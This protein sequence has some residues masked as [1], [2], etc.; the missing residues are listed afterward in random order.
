MAPGALR[1]GFS[2]IGSMT[3]GPDGNIYLVERS[4]PEIRVYS[5]EGDRLRTFGRSGQGPGEFQSPGSIGF[6]ADTLW[7]ADPAGQRVTMF[8]ETGDVLETFPIPGVVPLSSDVAG[9]LPMAMG[10]R[11]RSDGFVYFEE[12]SAVVTLGGRDPIPD[13][14]EVPLLR[15]DR[16]GS[17]PDTAGEVRLYLRP[18]NDE[19]GPN[20]PAQTNL[21]RDP[22]PPADTPLRF[23]TDSATIVIERRVTSTSGYPRF[24]VYR[25]LLNG[26]TQYR[27]VISYSPSE[28]TSAE[29]DSLVAARGESGVPAHRP[30]V[31][32]A[33]IGDD[34]TLWVRGEITPEPDQIWFVIGPDGNGHGRVMLPSEASIRWIEGTVVYVVEPDEFDV[35]WLVRYRLDV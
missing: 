33:R 29:A 31:S 27:W 20:R 21:D 2:S 10:P 22:G 23:Q 34:G 6:L 18:S 25:V 1:E 8:S 28:L 30:P 13:S 5:P 12:P 14:M 24:S 7:V 35:P 16:A 17:R 15:V 19:G 26:T 4:V 32:G 3:T 9:V 11:L